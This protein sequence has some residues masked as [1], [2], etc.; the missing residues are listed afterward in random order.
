MKVGGMFSYLQCHGDYFCEQHEY[1]RTIK[2]SYKNHS[3]CTDIVADNHTN[4]D[5]QVIHLKWMCNAILLEMIFAQTEWLIKVSKFQPLSHENDKNV[6][7]L[8]NCASAFLMYFNSWQLELDA[9]HYAVHSTK[10]G[11]FVATLCDETPL[12]LPAGNQSGFEQKMPWSDCAQCVKT[13]VENETKH[14]RS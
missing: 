2:F 11:K 14:C 10:C 7:L 1:A 6:H 5:L 4:V 9:H 13:N 3:K 8:L 12:L